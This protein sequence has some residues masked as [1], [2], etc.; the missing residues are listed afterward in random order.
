MNIRIGHGYDLHR[1]VEQRPLIIGG[2]TIP[3]EKGLL[4]HSDAD[5]LLHSIT[6]A[7]LGALALG[8]IGTFFPDHDPKWKGADSRQL[9]GHVQSLI[10]ERGWRIGNIDTVLIAEEPRL[11]PYIENIRLSVAQSLQIEMD[12]ISVKAT[13]NEGQDSI[14]QKLSIAAMATIL[15]YKQ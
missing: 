12:Q 4:G 1:L 11:N 8:D 5:V 13:T 3:F 9:L 15:I 6:D 14:G 10:E 2:V 7:M